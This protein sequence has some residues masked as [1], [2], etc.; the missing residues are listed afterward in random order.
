MSDDNMPGQVD[1]EEIVD[2]FYDKR[3][4]K[5]KSSLERDSLFEI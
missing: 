3:Q 2:R 1:S 5:V 4:K